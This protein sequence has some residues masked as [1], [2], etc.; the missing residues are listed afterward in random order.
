MI[1]YKT[2]YYVHFEKI[3]TV[4]GLEKNISGVA[5]IFSTTRILIKNE[6]KKKVQFLE[7]DWSSVK[8]GKF[9]EKPQKPLLTFEKIATF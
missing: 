7:S 8:F 6:K 9:S 1:N 3:L 4:W 5:E 2:L